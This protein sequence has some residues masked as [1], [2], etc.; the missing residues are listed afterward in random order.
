[1]PEITL[2]GRMG[3]PHED[4]GD[5]GPVGAQD[6][7][8]GRVAHHDGP[9]P[10]QA[11]G[12]EGFFEHGGIGFADDCRIPARPC[13]DC[14]HQGAD[15]CHGAFCRGKCPV[16]VRGHEERPVPDCQGRPADHGEGGGLVPPQDHCFAVLFSCRQ[17]TRHFHLPVESRLADDPCPGDSLLGEVFGR[18]RARG[19]DLFHFG[20][21]AVPPQAV[22]DPHPSGGVV[23]QEPYGLSHASERIQA[24]RSSRRGLTSHVQHAVEVEKETVE[25]VRDHGHHSFSLFFPV[26]IVSSFIGGKV[27]VI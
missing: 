11:R 20:G 7:H 22:S 2:H 5:A 3:V 24:L 27:P 25:H 26:F 18:G 19:D 14:L 13:A 17:N 4:G 1:M 23:R 9:L 10:G 15:P 12:G 16:D 21:D 6:I 8:L